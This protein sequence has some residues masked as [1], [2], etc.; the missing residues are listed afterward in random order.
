MGTAIGDILPLAIGIALS[1]LPIV[2]VVLVLFTPRARANGLAFL[3]GWAGGM[4]VVGGI[5]LVVSDATDAASDDGGESTLSGA[6][7]LALGVGLLLLAVRSWRSR[8]PEGVEPELPRWMGALDTFTFPKSLA[9]GAV[10]SSVNPKNLA[11]LVAGVATISAAGLSGG[12]AAGVLVVFVL[13]ASLSIAV[14][15]GTYLALGRDRAEV[16]LTPTKDWLS[17]NNAAVLAILFLI[18]GAKLLGDGIRILS[19]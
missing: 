7:R 15:V 17:R 16:V 2:A 18:F 14:P 10:L 1:P 3:A 6:V 11:L 19:G 13:L 5:V 4:L 8:P 12:E 9:T